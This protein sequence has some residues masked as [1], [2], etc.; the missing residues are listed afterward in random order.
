MIT[1][2][3]SFLQLF[4]FECIIFAK[5]YTIRIVLNMRYSADVNVE[6]PADI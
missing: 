2:L 3:H 4:L 6:L 5:A 1:F